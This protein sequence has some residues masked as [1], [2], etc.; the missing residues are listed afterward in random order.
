MLF[1][2]STLEVPVLM[3]YPEP[4][5]RTGILCSH[6]HL[7]IVGNVHQL[8]NRY[9]DSYCWQLRFVIDLS[10][11]EEEKANLKRKHVEADDA[12]DMQ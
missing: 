5:K 12:G 8:G 9:F 10:E 3:R 6:C 1:P 4:K 11:G 2:D 7:E